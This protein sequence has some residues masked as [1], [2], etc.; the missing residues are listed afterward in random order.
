MLLSEI[1]L[2]KLEITPYRAERPEPVEGLTA[3]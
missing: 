3:Y 1:I 2:M